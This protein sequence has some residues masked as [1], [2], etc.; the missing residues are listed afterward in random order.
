M[1]KM[2]RRPPT[3]LKSCVLYWPNL[4]QRQEGRITIITITHSLFYPSKS[5][6]HD[7]DKYDGQDN[8]SGNYVM[9][10]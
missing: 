9:I 5:R 10:L 6:S 4:Y 2:K 3:K 7:K 8:L 1:I